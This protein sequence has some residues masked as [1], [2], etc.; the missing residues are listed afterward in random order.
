MRGSARL[1]YCGT[2]KTIG[3]R[4]GQRA[5]MLLNHDTAFLA[6]LLLHYEGSP[7]WSSPYR[8]FNCMA[9][10]SEIPELLDYVAAITIVLAHYRVADHLEDSGRWHWRAAERFLSPR[11]RKAAAQ[12]RASGFPVDE[13]DSIL[14][15]QA[16]REAG[17][18][19][20][21]DVAEPT[22][23]AT[24]MVFAHRC[25]ELYDAGYKFGYL[26]YTLDAFEDRE[27][28]ARRGSFNALA[29]FPEIDGRAEIL[30]TLGEIDL[31]DVFQQRLRTNVETRLGMRPRVLC[32]SSRKT[33]RDRWQDAVAFARRMQD[34]EK[35]GAAVF[36]SAIAIAFLFPHHARGSITSRECLTIPFN[37]M[38]LSTFFSVPVDKE[39]AKQGCASRCASC[40]CDSSC[41]DDCDCGDCC[42]DSICS[43]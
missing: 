4:Y 14:R 37:L 13:L 20:F 43:C 28:D 9:K 1:P 26:I 22:A 7:Q 23:L 6:E 5:R 32:C 17:A 24:A 21:R 2:C 11:F 34:R 35:V 25:P 38:A 27:K 36:V 42:C 12:L 18:K 8:S 39:T 19:S 3:A 40:C 10:P 16:K 31:P 15:T 33:W 41:C 30:K 29:R